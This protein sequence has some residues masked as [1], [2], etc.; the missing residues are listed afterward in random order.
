[1]DA[2]MTPER[3]KCTSCGDQT[4]PLKSGKHGGL[5]CPDC[6]DAIKK[7]Q[8]DRERNK[9][10]PGMTAAESEALVKERADA[11]NLADCCQLNVETLLEQWEV[12]VERINA[13]DLILCWED[14]E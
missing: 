1:M 14:G 3:T 12:A 4:T 8:R 5:F 2:K 7:W 13:I 10:P 9:Q 6:T 11:V